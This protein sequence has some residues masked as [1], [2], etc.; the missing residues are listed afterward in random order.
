VHPKAQFGGLGTGG[1][2]EDGDGVGDGK[3]TVDA[4]QTVVADDEK[5]SP[6]TMAPVHA[7]VV[8]IPTDPEQVEGR[9]VVKLTTEEQPALY[10]WPA[11][12]TLNPDAP[13]TGPQMV[14]HHSIWITLFP[15]P[16]ELRKVVIGI[17]VP[18]KNEEE[19]EGAT[20]V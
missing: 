6:E 14:E 16:L 8:G 3:G 2:L 1:G 5:L 4:V 15:F 7:E 10:S 17:M 13:T 20:A 9:G 18:V 11:I 19:V 12:W